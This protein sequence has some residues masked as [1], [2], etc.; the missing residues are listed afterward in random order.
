MYPTLEERLMKTSTPFLALTVSASLLFAAC[1]SSSDDGNGG[2]GGG[3]G[4]APAIG[5]STQNRNVDPTGMT[6]DVSMSEP[7]DSGAANMPGTWTASS[8]NVTAAALQPDTT[9]VRLTMDAVQI[10]GTATIGTVAPTAS[11][12]NVAFTAIPDV[13][14]TVTISD[15]TTATTFEFTDGAGAAGSNVEVVRGAGVTDT[16]SAFRTAVN[17]QSFGMT[18]AD[19]AGDSV[20]LTNQGFG[21]SGNVA[22]TEA[23]GASNQMAVT[24]MTG[25][26]GLEDLDGEFIAGAVSGVAMT[27]TDTTQPTASSIDG[28]T[29]EGYDNDHVRVVFDD[30]MIQ[31]EVENQ[32]N[33][34]IESPIGTSFDMTGATI[35]YD[36]MTRTADVL[37]GNTVPGTVAN[38]NNLQTGSSLAA[39]FSG[40]RDI[41]GN[42]VMATVIGVSAV[43]GSNAGDDE[44]PRILTAATD[45]VGT[46]VQIRFSEPMQEA[47]HGDLYTAGNDPGPRL[48]LADLDGTPAVASTGSATFASQPADGDTVTISDGILP[49]TFE[50]DSNGIFVP[51]NTQVTIGGSTDATASALAT[52]VDGH[53]ALAVSSTATGSTADFTN[54]AAGAMG[55][56][57]ITSSN[58]A[59]VGVSGMAGG[60][61]VSPAEFPPLS[62][63]YAWH[64]DGMGVQLNY[65]PSVP[66]TTDD[67]MEIYG[68]SDL[69]GNQVFAAPTQALVL[70]DLTVPSSNAAGANTTVV[71]GESNDTIQFQFGSAMSPANMTVPS[72]F[73]AGALDLSQADFAFNGTDTVSIT[74]RGQMNSDAQFGTNYDLTVVDNAATP[75]TTIQGEPLPADLIESV[76]A[77]GDNIG[78]ASATAFVAAASSPN[79][80]VVVFSE[81]TEPVGSMTLINYAIGGA[82]PTSIAQLTPRAYELTFAAQPSATDLLTIETA[83]ATD[84][85]GSP[86]LVQMSVALGAVDASAP[87]ATTSATTV[88]GRGRDT[89]VV[90]F[91]E[92]MD[93]QSATNPA[94]YSVSADASSVDLTGATFEYDS[95]SQAT[96]ITL[97]EVS[98]FPNGAMIAVVMTGVSDVS[99]NNLAAQPAASAA[100]GDA[101]APGFQSSFVNYQADM[102]GTSVDVLFD[103]DVDQAYVETPGNWTTDGPTNVVSVALVAPRIARVSTNSQ[104]Q[105]AEVLQLT[106]LP[107]RAGNTSGMIMIDPAE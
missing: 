90:D 36:S 103:E 44:P 104:M 55:N 2:G 72:N 9:T 13:G 52:A 23:D 26:G 27:S 29:I 31:S 94:N 96:T 75:I 73:S 1:S 46:M 100:S 88:S 107:D 34:N 80:A 93:I 91:D 82:N 78:V 7:I 10:P 54:D 50:F 18:A 32:A 61:D 105:T 79:A 87:T 57:L 49:A 35:S 81:A 17:A 28:E 45:E 19:G 59:A 4:T 86:A 22:I 68:V 101:V 24:G 97:G 76:A 64:A 60:A 66:S 71:S 25:G 51:A 89:L 3:G 92:A 40:M 67:A 69:A 98:D 53:P 20:D 62:A 77:G 83:A 65:S 33:W 84:R 30:D 16:I 95:T 85:G 56:V 39:T 43:E 106:A 5:G 58:P 21:V 41:G 12:G 74:L 15:G 42:T 99:G 11:T 47:A 6:V 70:E 37:L 102:L 8:G 38:A 48:R 14:D 63:G